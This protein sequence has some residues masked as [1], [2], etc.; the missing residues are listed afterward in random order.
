MIPQFFARICAASFLA[1]AF[2]ASPALAED[3]AP[4]VFGRLQYDY[5]RS[6]G[7]DSGFDLD[8]GEL[9]TG[10]IGLSAKRGDTKL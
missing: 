1:L 9:R 7:D 8:R 6:S 2:A 5:T 4:E 3:W 10:R